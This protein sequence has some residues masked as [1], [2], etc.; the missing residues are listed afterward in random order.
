MSI[1]CLDVWIIPE[2]SILPNKHLLDFLKILAIEH[3]LTMLHQPRTPE[4]PPV[5]AGFV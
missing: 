3:R 2:T 5:A 4:S 1:G